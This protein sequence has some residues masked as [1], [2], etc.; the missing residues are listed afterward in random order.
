MTTVMIAYPPNYE[1]LTKA[2]RITG[3][4]GIIFS[5]GSTIYNP[6]N[7]DISPDLFAHEAVHERQQRDIWA[8]AANQTMDQAVRTW[9]RRYIDDPGFRFDQELEAYRA[10]W[11]FAQAAYN[12]D[13][14]R[15]LLKHISNALS[16]PMY[17]NLVT[18]AEAKRRITA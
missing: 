1:Q 5:W 10:Q 2:F 9:W 11:E 12:R 14:R 15:K 4:P 7:V 16:G 8:E 17:G 18:P 13:H 3:R 6:S